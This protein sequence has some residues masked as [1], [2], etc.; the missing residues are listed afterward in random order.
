MSAQ[1]AQTLEVTT[2]NDRE[3]VIVRS[4]N[5]ER[6]RVWRAFTEP[7]FVKRWLLGPDGWS[8]PVCDIDLRPGGRFHY[9]WRNAEDGMEFGLIGAYLEVDVPARIVHRE[10]SD[11]A[12]NEGDATVTTTFVEHNGL[13]TVTLTARYDSRELRDRAIESGMVAGTSMSFDRLVDALAESNDASSD[14]KPSP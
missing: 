6:A 3:I 1:P 4:F 10:I 7:E 2:P 13:T 5:A 9:R 12:G 14:Q 11:E 8:M